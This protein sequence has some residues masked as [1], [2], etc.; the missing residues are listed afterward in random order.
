MKKIFAILLAVTMLASMATVV[1]AA[2]STTLTTTVPTATYTLNIPAN[3]E[4]AF[5]ATSTKIGTV[6]VTESNGFAAGKDLV[7]T[8][9]YDAIECENTTTTIPFNLYTYT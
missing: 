5:G 4:I 8:V 3:Q 9:S 2:E 6:T 7:V 1:S